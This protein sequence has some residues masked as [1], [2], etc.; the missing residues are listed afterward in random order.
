MARPSA[1]IFVIVASSKGLA[2]SRSRSMLTTPRGSR[3][4]P[5]PLAPYTGS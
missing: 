5:P 2:V 4:L 3:V 1:K